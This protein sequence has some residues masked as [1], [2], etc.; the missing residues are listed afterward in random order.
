MTLNAATENMELPALI[1]PRL[2]PSSP[3][4]GEVAARLCVIAALSRRLVA[5]HVALFCLLWRAGVSNAEVEASDRRG[6]PSSMESAQG[7]AAR[8]PEATEAPGTSRFA[9]IT[10]NDVAEGGRRLA[11]AGDVAPNTRRAY[12]SALR[13]LDAWLRERRAG[14]A[15]D[16]AA[17][18]EYLAVLAV[19]RR[20]VSSA[21]QVVA[22]VKWRAKSQGAASP[23]GV[24]T[25]EALKH[26]RK[27]APTGPG[28]VRGISWEEADRM[29]DLAAAAGTARGLR[30]AALIAMTSDALLRVSEVSNVQIRDVE[31][32]ADGSAR[33]LV[34]RSKTD[35]RGRG[36]VLFLGPPTAQRV[37]EWIAAAKIEKGA[38]FRRISR[39][40]AVGQDGIGAASVRRVIVQC[41]KA[42]GVAGRVS[43]HSL[44]VGSAQSLSKRGAGLVAMQRAGRWA[45]PDMPAGYTRSQA[46]AEGAVARLRHRHDSRAQRK[47]SLT[48]RKTGIL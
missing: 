29:R 14:Q 23:A 32:E 18:A 15:L 33:L 37:R 38:L 8:T 39:A 34:R 35:R 41:A 4:A 40:G 21:A 10:E 36:A 12:L 24:K 2:A 48:A 5:E 31:F 28:Q 3:F 16:D 17:L 25:A 22:A 11:A 44:R 27:S 26:Y 42:A 19:Q 13:G 6:E 30:D 20:C 1:V 43:G 7:S 47:K 45:S 46:A 9:A